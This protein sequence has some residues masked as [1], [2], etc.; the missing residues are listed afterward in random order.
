MVLELVNLFDL[1]IVNPS[2]AMSE[3][4]RS[5]VIASPRRDR[6]YSVKVNWFQTTR[7][8]LLGSEIKVK[9]IPTVSQ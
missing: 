2:G 7:P 6:V 8:S 1:D 9:D 3:Y 4:T 5:H